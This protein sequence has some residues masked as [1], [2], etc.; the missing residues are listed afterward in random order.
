MN[1]NNNNHESTLCFQYCVGED[2]YVQYGCIV[3]NKD[4][5]KKNEWQSYISLCLEHFFNTKGLLQSNQYIDIELYDNDVLMYPYRLSGHNDYNLYID[6]I[7]KQ[8]VFN[9][10]TMTIPS[11]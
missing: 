9:G 10:N 5:I 2:P 11:H 7:H 1:T 3:A 8:Y 4:T 6:V